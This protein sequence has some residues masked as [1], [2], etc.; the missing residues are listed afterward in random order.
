LTGGTQGRSGAERT[1]NVGTTTDGTRLVASLYSSRKPG[2]SARS[3]SSPRNRS[4]S[5]SAPDCATHAY[6]QEIIDALVRLAQEYD[7]VADDLR[8]GAVNVRHPELMNHP[9]RRR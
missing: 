6:Q 9:E 2:S 5:C 7:E 3:V 4:S 8:D 1:F